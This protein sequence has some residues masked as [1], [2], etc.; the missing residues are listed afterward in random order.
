MTLAGPSIGPKRFGSRSSMLIAIEGTVAD[1][2]VTIATMAACKVRHEDRRQPLTHSVTKRGNR[3]NEMRPNMWSD[4]RCLHPNHHVVVVGHAS[5]SGPRE[6]ALRPM[7]SSCKGDTPLLGILAVGVME[8]RALLFAP[9][10]VAVADIGRLSNL[11]S[12]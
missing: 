11:K 1:V 6:S 5:C 8:N 12:G 2:A 9:E 3:P 7:A 4:S 10:S